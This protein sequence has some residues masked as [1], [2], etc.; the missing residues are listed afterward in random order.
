MGKEKKKKKEELKVVVVEFRVSM[1]CNA[2]ERTVARTISK[3]KGIEKFST[4]MNQHK[5]VV[6]GRIDPKK[7]L[8]KLKKKTGK[9]VEILENKEDPAK[10]DGANDGANDGE[11]EGESE[12]MVAV[13]QNAVIHPSMLGYCCVENE[14]LMMFSDE[15]PNACSMM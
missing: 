11:G 14:V 4:N 5:V 13:E 3:I 7:V 6:T 8:K 9:K 1:H 2:C 12:T 15:N 10:E